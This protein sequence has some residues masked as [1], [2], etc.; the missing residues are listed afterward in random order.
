MTRPNLKA[1]LCSVMIA[2]AACAGFNADSSARQHQPESVP[3]SANEKRIRDSVELF[4][5]ATVKELRKG[6]V[7]TSILTTWKDAPRSLNVVSVELSEANR[8]G[9]TCPD[10]YALTSDQCKEAGAFL[11]INAQYFGDNKP[12]GFLKI[13]G[14]V[15]APGIENSSTTFAGGVFVMNGMT[16]DIRKVS[17]NPEAALLPD[18]TVLCCGPVLLDDG[19]FEQMST[20]SNHH[21]KPHPRTAIGITEDGRILLVTVDGRFEGKAIGMS[22]E[23]LQELMY[24]LGAHKALNLDGGG[25]TTMWIE[26]HGIVN[27]ACDGL[28]WENP[29]ERAVSSI[30]YIR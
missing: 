15:K 12:R 5:D 16:P 29:V 21:I 8:L 27:H 10:G 19:K 9:I 25:S 4:K 22:T 26:G 23:L 17:G 1:L 14:E 18:E 30:I 24:I 28:N 6:I 2:G 11:G 20:T 7:W 13:N 3:V